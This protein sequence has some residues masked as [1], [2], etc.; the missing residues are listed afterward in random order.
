MANQLREQS[1][2][3]E[4]TSKSFKEE[5]S[6]EL[7]TIDDFE[8]AEHSSLLKLTDSFEFYT[9]QQKFREQASL[10]KATCRL[11]ASRAY[12]VLEVICGF[13]FSPERSDIFSPQMRLDDRRTLIPSDFTGE[14]MDV[15]TA[16]A[17]EIDHPLLK[18]RIADLV[19][20]Q[21]RKQHALALL[22]ADSYCHAVD[23]FL[24]D[25]LSYSYEPGAVIPVKIV[26][27]IE[28][29]F[30]IVAGA[31]IK[32]LSDDIRKT[33]SRAHQI[34]LDKTQIMAY[35]KLSFL[36][37]SQGL[38]EWQ[39]L[40]TEAETL[41]VQIETTEYPAAVQ[42][43]WELAAHG[44]AK[45]Q[46]KL[47]SLRCKTRSVDQTL[48]MR[49]TV[50]SAMAKAY[51][52]R[53]AIGELRSI[54]G[55]SERI[56]F[57]KEELQNYE[58]DATS[59][60]VEFEIPVEIKDLQQE[61]VDDFQQR[62]ISDMLYQLAFIATLPKKIEL[63]ANC[64]KR[65]NKSFLSS[66]FSKSYSDTEGKVIAESPSY[67][68][69][70]AP[71]PEWFDHESLTE[72]NQYYFHIVNGLVKP[73]CLT[74]MNN[75]ALDDRHL[76]PIVH[77]SVFVPPGHEQIFALGFSRMIQGDMMSACHLLIPNMENSLRHL[78]KNSR[79]NTARMK[80]DLTQ[81]DQSISIIFNN[82]KAELEKV[83][84]IDTTY[85]I[86]LLFNLKGGPM[87]RHE[88][89]HGKL[90]AGTCF[91]PASIYAC[92]LMYSLTMIPLRRCWQSH[93]EP[94]LKELIC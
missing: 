29:S 19:W 79:Q 84:G 7:A 5:I 59:E 65:V 21:R 80:P 3:T 38:L 91:S 74:I 17:E 48:R 69:G 40:A 72:L 81:E 10:A 71:P 63:H 24:D 56:E 86:N 47:S 33:W 6:L 25:K 77:T 94:A 61:V 15:L 78:L 2:T 36:G 27:L 57:L 68:M 75:Y 41:A 51:W 93:I 50:S 82:K 11:G 8:S 13:H 26:E 67:Q 66:I 53:H 49:E 18:A 58:G 39:A 34:A 31:R 22:A 83:I 54:G 32:T 44:Y 46:D 87:L 52:T 37:Q 92:W 16:I 20:H 64:L 73:A 35:C 9:M 4:P 14:Q 23:F 1:M 30:Q 90:T 28:R 43:L 89:A 55:L 12:S 42:K 76:M 62:E 60:F 85:I 70:K 88:I 45:A